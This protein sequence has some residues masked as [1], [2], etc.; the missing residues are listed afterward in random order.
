MPVEIQQFEVINDVPAA[1]PSAPPGQSSPSA[2]PDIA[3][4]LTT[5][6]REA[7]VRHD[8]LRAD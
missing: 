3:E 7:G 8:R 2:P 4:L 5:W 1:A 6:H